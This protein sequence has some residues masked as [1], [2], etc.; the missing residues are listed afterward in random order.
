MGIRTGVDTLVG[1]A[2]DSR[3]LGAWKGRR[4]VNDKARVGI[5]EMIRRMNEILQS[6]P[7]YRDG[8]VIKGTDPY[9]HSGYDLV[10]APS[11]FESSGVLHLVEIRFEKKYIYDQSLND[12]APPKS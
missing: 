7:E 12:V 1:R 6:L 10:G 3:C 4:I 2:H 11:Q 5:G 9:P 8:M